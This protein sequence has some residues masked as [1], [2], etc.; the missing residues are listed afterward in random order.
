MAAHDSWHIR[1]V[2]GLR[3]VTDNPNERGPAVV[4]NVHERIV[5]GTPA[6]VWPIL[7]DLGTLYP[8]SSGSIAFPEGL[9]PG[10]PV[11]H[12]GT[13][14]S[15]AIVEPGERLWFDVA[16]AMTGGH[17]FELFPVCE[18]HTLVRHSVGGRLKGAFALLWPVVIRRQHDRAV[19]GILDNLA[20][21]A[22]KAGRR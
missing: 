17:G 22:Q 18:S 5:E 14:Y 1:A 15:V 2:A 9:Y 19:E 16:W 12:D 10:A 20:A 4:R 7:A 3:S 13:K 8:K 21:A 11:R 6:E